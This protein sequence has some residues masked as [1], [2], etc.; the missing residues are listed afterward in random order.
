MEVEPMTRETTK[1]VNRSE[2]FVVSKKSFK[3]QYAQLYFTRLML[4]LPRIRE[5]VKEK[6]PGVK[7]ESD[8]DDT[9]NQASL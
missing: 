2:R 4:T 5:A 6:F 1:Y 9:E 7:G 3:E 8:R